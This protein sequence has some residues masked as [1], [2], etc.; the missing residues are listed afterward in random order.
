MYTYI[1]YVYIYIYNICIYMCVLWI[2]LKCKYLYVTYV[3]S[4][5]HT[6][7]YA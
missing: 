4:R 6:S 3:S 7:I 1:I 2:E 5:E